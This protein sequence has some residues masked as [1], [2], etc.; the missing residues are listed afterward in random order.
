[1][2]RELILHHKLEVL[3]RE[4]CE[5]L[6]DY[7]TKYKTVCDELAAI[8]K[9]LTENQ[10]SFWMLNGLGSNYQMFTTMILRPPLLAYSKLLSMLHSYENRILLQGSTSSIQQVAFLA[11]KATKQKQPKQVI[12]SENHGF[13]PAVVSSALATEV[14]N[15]LAIS[16]SVSKPPIQFE[17][18]DE[19]LKEA[20]TKFKHVCLICLKPGHSAHRCFK[21]FNRDFK[22]PSLR[23]EDKNGQHALSAFQASSVDISQWLPDSCA[24]SHMTGDLTLFDSYC[25]YDKAEIVLIGNGK[26]LSIQHIE[27]VILHTANGPIV[28]NN[29]LHV[30]LLQ[31]NLFSITQFT[32]NF[33]CL[34]F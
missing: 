32:S 22:T 5:T 25:P 29:V 28:L 2:D 13:T 31:Q 18:T 24:S 21:R 19:E 26:H 10:K 11:N 20:L 3:R 23:T 15:K 33:D 12:S 6:D 27:S 9:P 7:L 4:Q 8:C 14:E 34:S 16:P 17:R 1:M 30:P